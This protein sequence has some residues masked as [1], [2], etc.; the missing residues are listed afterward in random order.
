MNNLKNTKQDLLIIKHMNNLTKTNHI[1]VKKGLHVAAPFQYVS[2]TKYYL[3]M[4]NFFISCSS[5]SM[6]R[7]K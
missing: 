4:M 1:Y 7:T 2:V 5:P 6:M 3:C